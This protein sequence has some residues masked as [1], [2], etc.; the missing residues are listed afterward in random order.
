MFFLSFRLFCCFLI[1]RL[2]SAVQLNYVTS[3]L[4]RTFSIVLD[5][6]RACGKLWKDLKVFIL[7]NNDTS[8]LLPWLPGASYEHVVK[9]TIVEVEKRGQWGTGKACVHNRS[10]LDTQ[11]FECSRGWEWFHNS[12]ICRYGLLSCEEK[13]KPEIIAGN[14]QSKMVWSE[15]RRNGSQS[16]FKLVF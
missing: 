3:E 1:I 5:I 12:S 6:F 16:K 15:T 14:E 8:P 9:L 11:A 4:S 10:S 2:F 13:M 7:N